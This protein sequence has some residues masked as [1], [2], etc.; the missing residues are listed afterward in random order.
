MEDSAKTVTNLDEQ[1]KSGMDAA[2]LL[3]EMGLDVT[4]YA[5]TEAER[6]AGMENGNIRL[7]DGS[8]RV[9]LNAGADGQGV[10][11]FALSHEFT[12]FVEE[13]SPKKFRAFTDIL[14]EEM[15]KKGAD[16]S[17][18]IEAKA[19]TLGKMEE[20]KGLSENE[21][22][23]LAYSEVTAEMM[24]T[25]LTDTDVMERISARLQQTDKSLWGR[26]KD[27]L[28]GLVDRLKAAYKGLNPDSG[29]A[30]L[31]RETINS[32]ERV[33]DA[34]ADAASDA[35]VNYRLQD[36]QKN[37]AR[38]GVQF[39]QREYDSIS[40]QFSDEIS[41]WVKDG[42]DG[43]R[44]FIL[45][46][47]GEVLQGLG[48]IESDIYMNSDKI[49]TILDEHPEITLEEIR[50]IPKIIND[51]ILILKSRNAGRSAQNTRMTMFSSVK[52]QNGLPVMVVFDLRPSENHFVISDMQKVTSAYTKTTE[53]T[54]FVENSFIMYADKKRTASL[55][56]TIGF[57]MPIELLQ[58]GYIGSVT[59]RGQNVNIYGEKFSDVFQ[60]G[61]V[62]KSSRDSAGNALTEAQ[63]R[64][65]ADSQ[66]RDEDG[67]LKVVYHGSPSIFTEFSA[68][69]MSSHGS[70][71]GQGFY[72]TDYKPMAEGYQ[73][74]GGQLL[75]GYLNIQKPLSDSD[76]TLKRA[77]VRKL[78]QALDPTGDDLVLNYDSKGG[79]G[80]PSRTWYT[81]A[82]NDTLSAVMNNESDSEILG[83]LANAMGNYGAVLEKA[84]S[85]LGYDG[86]IVS[87]KY[88]NANVYVAFDSSQFKNADNQNPTGARDIRYSSRQRAE[89]EQALEE[90][91]AQQNEEFRTMKAAYD[92]ARA[93]IAQEYKLEM[94]Q[95]ESLSGEI[96][97]RYQNE[98]LDALMDTEDL[99]KKGIPQLRKQF[100]ELAEKNSGKDAQTLSARKAEYNRLLDEFQ[101]NRDIGKL[102][103]T[104]Q[105]QRARAKAKVES[106]RKTVQRGKLERTVAE[107]NRRLL[108]PSKT[109]YVPDSLQPAVTMAMEA[110]TTV[111]QQ[112]TKAAGVLS[113][114][115]RLQDAYKA[116]TAANAGTF[117][118]EYNEGILDYIDA[119]KEAIGETKYHEMSLEQLKAVTDAYT[120]ILSAIRNAN[121]MHADNLT[122]GYLATAQAAMEELKGKPSKV[123]TVGELKKTLEQ[124]SWN[125]EKPYYAFQRLGSDTMMRLYQNLRKGEDGWARDFA[126]ARAY[127]M[128]AMRKYNYDKWKDSLVEI[129][130][131]DG[132]KVALNLEER[133]S[134]YA[135]SRRDQAINHLTKDGFMLTDSK[136]GGKSYSDY[137]AY[138]LSQEAVLEI[139]NG[140]LLELTALLEDT[141]NYISRSTD[142]LWEGIEERAGKAVDWLEAHRKVQRDS[143]AQEVLDFM[144]KRHVK[145]SEAQ[146]G[147]KPLCGRRSSHS[148]IVFVGAYFVPVSATPF[149]YRV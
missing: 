102:R 44:Q 69:F 2:K 130:T 123:K 94:E 7:S 22:N 34:F 25:A 138:N 118:Q 43:D 59:Y 21:L 143:Y 50:Q 64:Y 60:K 72:F 35:V 117:T 13:M 100:R 8:I 132:K 40:K 10:M 37:N 61:T 74:S 99:G 23:D 85:V 103:V 87:G 110:I 107:I 96:T 83:E 48:A 129:E 70:S 38:E 77:E 104:I 112:D 76:V 89:V 42:Q 54:S 147:E 115:D 133:L 31:A 45:G 1:Q 12:H 66:V 124:A 52:G 127:A 39:S 27:F 81:R 4:V 63:Q 149:T 67:N 126:Q 46:S 139:R 79:M 68:D 58:S 93:K 30:Q 33:L 75:E 26:I 145:L 53:A 6:K 82:V 111:R 14:F 136:R 119:A 84:R 121:K 113:A 29:I 116:L 36:G 140:G 86:Y 142:F 92:T 28:K 137:T 71:E 128:E 17:A 106:S 20:N 144:S 146:L 49:N 41:Q 108:N 97:A 55:L 62:L 90:Y 18:L 148:G 120:G 57:H 91:R 9:D 47:T 56:R 73:K 80:Y 16:V 135:Y 122:Q 11:A 24:E 101:K 114:L 88:D 51:P 78:L 98:F 5:S 15:G 95:M 141:Y 105:Q 131:A 109:L 125:N 19:Q 32:S 3:A 134:L 65:F